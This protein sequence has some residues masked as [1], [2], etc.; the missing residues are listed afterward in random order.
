[1][2]YLKLFEQFG[3]PERS[4]ALSERVIN[5]AKL[6]TSS[7]IYTITSPSW[8][9]YI[10][11][12]TERR[13]YDYNEKEIEEWF[14]EQLNLDLVKISKTPTDGDLEQ[15]INKATKWLDDKMLEI[16]QDDSDY[17]KLVFSEK[18]FK[19]LSNYKPAK[20]I[21]VD[22]LRTLPNRKDII[23]WSNND[24]IKYKKTN[25]L[26]IVFMVTNGNPA[27]IIIDLKSGL[28]FLGGIEGTKRQDMIED[29]Y[30]KF[31]QVVT[32]LELTDVTLNIVDA[33][34]KGGNILKGNDIKNELPFKVIQVNSN[35]NTGTISVGDAF[36]V[37]GHWRL[38]QVGTGSEK[39]YKYIFINP[40][41]KTGIINRKAG[42]DIH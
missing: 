35:W 29:Y 36:G 4:S 14:D 10:K 40:Y 37:V 23:Q 25:D 11:G 9:N 39:R 22:V 13:P 18:S 26:I 30:S 21:R 38:A 32:Y 41:Q 34:A 27:W 1:M 15:I 5:E 16:N 8:K 7:L 20:D 12:V 6:T 3:L 19:N 28:D 24:V 33:G 31:M 42:K 17:R 2:K